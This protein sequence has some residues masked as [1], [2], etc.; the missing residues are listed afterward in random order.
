L[1]AILAGWTRPAALYRGHQGV[2]EFLGMLNEAFDEFTY[3]VL[4]LK[5][6]DDDRVLALLRVSARG[7]GRAPGPRRG[8]PSG[9]SGVRPDGDVAAR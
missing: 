9:V 7:K 5:E 6:L 1:D 4:E 8:S 2:R 3:D